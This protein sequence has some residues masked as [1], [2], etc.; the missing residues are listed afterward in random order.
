MRAT[1]LGEGT[2]DA[3]RALDRGRVGTP[4]RRPPAEALHDRLRHAPERPG[5][6][7]AVRRELRPDAGEGHRPIPA[8]PEVLLARPDHLHRLLDPDGGLHR[9]R[10]EVGL[11]LPAE[12]A[13]EEGRVDLDRRCRKGGERAV[14]P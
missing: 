1:V 10:D 5:R 9:R 3:G 12:A 11:D 8:V 6:D 4:A 13:A 7:P 14:T 2:L